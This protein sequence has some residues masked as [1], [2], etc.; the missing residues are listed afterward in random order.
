RVEDIGKTIRNYRMCS[1]H[2]VFGSSP[3]VQP[4]GKQTS[5][6][7]KHAIEGVYRMNDYIV[8]ATT[9]NGMIRAY[10]ISSTHLVE[11]TRRRQ[12]TWATTSAAIGR[13]ATVSAMMGAMLKGDDTLTVK[14]EGNGP[15]GAIIADAHANGNVRA[16]VSN[17]HVDFDL[18]DHGK[19]DVARAVGMEG[20]IS[21]IK[22][23]GL[24]E[25]FTGN[26]PIIS[27]E[28]SED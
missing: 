21:V 1:L 24:K 25:Y 11:E 8:K 18:N 5:H 3:P 13:V 27:G 28:I 17:P 9:Y 19:L 20:N 7:Q 14:V 22:D 12:D 6:K 26:V 15:A 2:K 4:D 10:A 23:L 16:Y